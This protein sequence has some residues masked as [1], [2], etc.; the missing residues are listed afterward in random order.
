MKRCILLVLIFLI[1]VSVL[2]AFNTGKSVLFADSYMLRAK[3]VEAAY[4]NP[5][6]LK[7]VKGI[8]F[9]LPIMNLGISV[10]NNSLDLDTYNYVVSQDF[11]DDEDKIKILNKIDGSLRSAVEGNISIIGFAFNNISFS[12]SLHLTG[13]LAVSERFV[14]LLLYGNTDSLY[15]FDKS[16]TDISGLSYADFTFGMGN[17]IIPFIPEPIPKI[18][19]G[20]SVSALVGVGDANTQEFNGYFNSSMEGLS[21]QQDISLHTGIGGYGQK[22]M[23]GLASNVTPQLEVGLTLDNLFGK[24]TWPFTTEARNISITADDVYASNIDEE[25][26]DYTS[27]TVDIDTYS[28]ELP[29]E[30]RLGALYSMKRANVSVDYLQGFK[31][32]I[33]NS[34]IGRISM[35]AQVLPLKFLPIGMGVCF[36]NSIYPWRVSY[37]IGLHTST[38]E[39]GFG[40]QSIKQLFPSYKSKGLSIG[41][42]I[43]VNI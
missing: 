18:R 38:G 15:V 33:N 24:I 34:N 29:P 11:L 39:I 25:F 30:L 23:L 4:W 14:D 12:S 8:D 5:A 2:N 13:R 10:N 35:A 22:V 1:S 28:T 36:G 26:Y 6:N 3:G 9:W 37:S 27:E 41:S 32:S 43:K 31:S 20:F 17:F 40:V 21:L 42:Y 16:T 19:A 7:Q